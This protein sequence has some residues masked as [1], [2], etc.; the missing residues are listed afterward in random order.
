MKSE[1]KKWNHTVGSKEYRKK[2]GEIFRQEQKPPLK[3]KSTEEN[4][5]TKPRNTKE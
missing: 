2:W 1:N 3:E 5:V 4:D